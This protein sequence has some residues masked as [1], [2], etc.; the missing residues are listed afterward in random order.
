MTT[1]W[2]PG[3]FI[4]AGNEVVDTWLGV[5]RVLRG[6]RERVPAPLAFALVL[7]LVLALV[8]PAVSW[9]AVISTPSGRVAAESLACIAR[10]AH[11]HRPRPTLTSKKST[12][13]SCENMGI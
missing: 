13:G 8:F 3:S 12:I 4:Y 6:R 2:S 5:R 11:M 1:S 7:A 9:S 10:R